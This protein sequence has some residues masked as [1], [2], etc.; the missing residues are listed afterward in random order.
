M[1]HNTISRTA[2]A[3]I[4]D[5]DNLMMK[6]TDFEKLNKLNLEDNFID[7]KIQK[8][9]DQ[10]F[11]VENINTREELNAWCGSKSRKKL[12]KYVASISKTHWHSIDTP[13]STVRAYYETLLSGYK[14]YNKIKLDRI[15]KTMT[16]RI[17]TKSI[18]PML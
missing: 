6:L 12:Y 3:I 7:I 15:N 14:I 8:A 5:L 1:S 2:L 4:R 16:N 17:M 9:I 13:E 11:C 10:I 18:L